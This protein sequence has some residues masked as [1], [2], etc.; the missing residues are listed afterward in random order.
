MNC[1]GRELLCPYR[2]ILK[3]YDKDIGIDTDVLIDKDKG[4][5]E[6]GCYFYLLC[7]SCFQQESNKINH[8]MIMAGKM[9]NRRKAHS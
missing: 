1:E 8:L 9:L 6:S 5:K 3:F 7:L 4:M 2:G